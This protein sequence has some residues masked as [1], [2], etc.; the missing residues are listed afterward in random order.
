MDKEELVYTH[1]GILFIHKKNELL[2]FATIWVELK[3]KSL[4]EISQ[5][6][7]NNI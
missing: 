3:S 2:P 4:G 5:R 7:T 6:K 1:T